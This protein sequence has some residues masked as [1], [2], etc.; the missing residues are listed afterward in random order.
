MKRKSISDRIFN[1][2]NTLLML[3]IT[4]VT[5]YIFWYC[6]VGAFSTGDDFLNGKSW[7]WPA[8]FTLD[9]FK[10]VLADAD[11]YYAFVVS[12][13]RTVVA[14]TLNVIF[15]MTVA[16]GMTRS[17][18]KFRGFY[19]IFMLITM[20][21][22]GGLIPTFILYD[23]LGLMDTF[24]VYVIPG[25]FSVYNMIIIRNSFSSIPQSVLEA[26]R[27]DGCGEYGILW[28]IVVPMSK[29]VIM[30]IVLF[31]AVGHWNDY[32]GTLMYTSD[33]ALQTAQ[34]Y[35]Y[36]MIVKAENVTEM[37]NQGV[38]A[39]PD[40]VI[41]VSSQ[42][43]RMAATVVISLPILIFYPFIQKHFVKGVLIGSIKE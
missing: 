28:R 3:I 27:V 40:L 22:G 4:L 17:D 42:S 5:F 29:G 32:Y 10:S 39:N 6:V 38:L 13:L 31:V 41:N 8:N 37:L 24:W 15:T 9:N 26:A 12:V 35:L 18:L 21:F 16:Y 34:Y 25:L 11:L 30:T 36:N 1:F 43:V 20:F 2:F 19:S 23:N 14:T 33:P 7:I